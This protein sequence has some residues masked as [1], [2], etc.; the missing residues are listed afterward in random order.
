MTKVKFIIWLMVCILPWGIAQ[1]KQ[2]ASKPIRLIHADAL[3]NITQNGQAVQELNG[4][5]H[6]VQDSLN[7]WCDKAT[8]F[9]EEGRL[10]F[11][12]NVLF[13][14][15][16]R[17]LRAFQ[18]IYYE[19]LHRITASKDVDILQ[20]TLE[21][22]C[23]KALYMDETGDAYFN[24]QVKLFDQRS[25]STI[26]GD[27][28]TYNDSMGFAKVMDNP[29]FTERD[30]TDSIRM[31][32]F[33]QQIEYRTADHLAV[34]RDSVRVLRG[35]I[36][37]TSQLLEYNRDAGWAVL[38]GEPEIHRENEVIQG[39]TI[40]LFFVDN[41]INRVLVNNHAYA[42]MSS[43]SMQTERM[44]WMR[45]RNMDLNMDNGELSQAIIIGQAQALYYPIEEGKRQGANRVSGDKITLWFQKGDIARIKVSGGTQGTYYPERLVSRAENE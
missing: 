25:H 28:G 31:Q 32:I 21:I 7:V 29:V 39:D 24:G 18:V 36:T 33:G 43:D 41:N 42:T 17:T 11:E 45:G 10:I 38:S 35:D 13:Q 14:D 5:V 15:T 20:D 26:E 2:E 23:Q 12:G 16:I 34:A 37:A 44:N 22:R 19:K 30:T 6:L 3:K 9:Q 1:E 4:S 40:S 8:H 27:R